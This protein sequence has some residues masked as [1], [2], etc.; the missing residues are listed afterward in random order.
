MLPLESVSEFH[1]MAQFRN[2]IVHYYDKIDPEQ[3]YAI[4]KGK[5]QSFDSFR[6]QIR[7]WI[8]LDENRKKPDA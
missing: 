3:V 8:D 2:K 6:N 4:F 5:L 7:C 1:M